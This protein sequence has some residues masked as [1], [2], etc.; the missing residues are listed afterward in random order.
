M[1]ERSSYW[2]VEGRPTAGFV[3]H[4]LLVAAVFCAIFL[5]WQIRSAVLLTFFGA[6]LGVIVAA[7]AAPFQKWL[8]M[9]RR[10]AVIA[11]CVALAVLIGLATWL[12]GA[13]MRSQVSDL[14]SRLPDAIAQVENT[15]GATIPLI[16]DQTPARSDVANGSARSGDGPADASGGALDLSGLSKA[17]VGWVTSFGFSAMEVIAN[18]ILVVVIGVFVAADPRTYRDGIVKLFSRKRRAEIGETLDACARALWL[19]LMAQLISMTVVGVLVG[20]GVW[21]LGLPAPL[22]LALFAGLTE[23][24]P[25]AGP[26]IGAAPAVLLAVTMGFDTVLWT[27][28]LFLAVQQLESNVITPLV[29]RKMVSIPPVALLFAV[30][31]FGLLFG[32]LGVVVAAPLAVV[33]FVAI[34]KLYVRDTLGEAT[35]VPGER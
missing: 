9:P 19:W 31:T 11:A 25:I 35:D 28:A 18:V 13:Q 1:D 23:F 34:K 21:A 6:V 15:F 22:A 5:L 16:G 27:I 12:V 33:S 26:F 32:P 29:E 17:A 2:G 20:L 30:L 7:A 10:W 3:Q 24:I 8:H 14:R 4:V